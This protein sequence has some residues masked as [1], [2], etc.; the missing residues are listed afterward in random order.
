MTADRLENNSPKWSWIEG[1]VDPTGES[2]KIVY[3]S[4]QD[5]D[6]DQW[7]TM[8]CIAPPQDHTFIIQ[9]LIA[10]SDSAM[11]KILQEVVR[12]ID[13]YLIE[14][15]ESDPWGYAKYHCGSTANMYSDCHWL[16]NKGN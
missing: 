14:K 12:E 4:I 8:A 10:A 11:V 16:Y 15:Q 5:T 9:F 2:I 1:E 13:F 6:R 3:G 7:V